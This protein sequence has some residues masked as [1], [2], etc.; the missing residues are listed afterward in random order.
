[1][2][3]YGLGNGQVKEDE[4]EEEG[5]E[6]EEEDEDGEKDEEKMEEK[7]EQGKH[8][9]ETATPGPTQKLNSETDT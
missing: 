3:I 1:M 8:V 7:V 5:D 9:T 4:E 6:G 2:N